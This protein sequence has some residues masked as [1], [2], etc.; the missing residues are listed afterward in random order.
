M[1]YLDFITDSRDREWLRLYVGQCAEVLRRVVNGHAQ[2]ILKASIDSLHYFMIWLG[3]GCRSA[4][5]IRLWKVED[6]EDDDWKK[7]RMNLL[8]ALF[9]QAFSTHHGVLDRILP[10]P[11]RDQFTFY[12]RPSYGLNLMTPLAQ[13]GTLIDWK[14]SNYIIPA[15]KTPD[16]Q[17]G[18]WVNCFRLRR[19]TAKRALEQK[20]LTAPRLRFRSDFDDCLRTAI[21]D[22]NL[23]KELKESMQCEQVNVNCSSI[24]APVP[25][26]GS[27]SAKVGFILDYAAVS[28]E[29]DS[30]LERP[31]DEDPAVQLPWSL[32]TCN[33]TESNILLWTY[34]FGKFLP[35]AEAIA[36]QNANQDELRLRHQQ[37]I[38]CSQVRII[39]LCGP[40]AEKAI[41]VP[42]LPRFTLKL[43]GF[44]YP[45]YLMDNPKRILIRCPPIP[46]EIWSKIGAESTQI[47]EG[48]RFAISLLGLQKE[49]LRPYSLETTSIIGVILR[50]ARCERLG[51][52]KMT[53]KTV[54]TPLLLWLQRKGLTTQAL[55]RVEKLAGSLSR[56]LLMILHALPRKTHPSLKRPM[57]PETRAI[58]NAERVRCYEPFDKD[59]FRQVTKIVQDALAEKEESYQKALQSLSPEKPSTL[60]PLSSSDP[61]TDQDSELEDSHILELEPF[62]KRA[63]DLGLL[64][65]RLS[66]T[67]PDRPKFKGHVWR[68]EVGIFRDKEYVYQMDPD[69]TRSRSINVN[70]CKIGFEKGENVGDGTIRVKIEVNPP[71][72]RHGK[73]YATDALDSDP[74]SRLAFR[75]R[76]KNSRGEQQE[77]YAFAQGRK[78]TYTAN[79][80]VD[81][82]VDDRPNEMIAK[83]SRRYLYFTSESK[84]PEELKRFVGGAY[85]ADI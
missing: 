37:L 40:R 77:K 66:E 56:G 9:C 11:G 43:R 49:G 80:L 73:C 25:F 6:H 67:N 63:V 23:F 83:T 51:R 55:E 41:G 27:T 74:A 45:I 22:D 58:K 38:D 82:L 70:Y 28:P 47:A 20:L 32:E 16:E 60:E 14:R 36:I 61:Y 35:L 18:L 52:E 68:Q 53:L 65:L 17:I 5:F 84:I 48:I 71:G 59:A 39:F 69:Q 78:S 29:E 79:T 10:T 3:N 31:N 57:D 13:V 30:F 62:C 24:T 12:E 76:Y 1:G 75:V 64:D 8:E 4:N 42:S 26:F 33:F 81:I 44:R 50:H 54:E 15:L 21:G 85:T 46:C 34:N 19:A 72:Q 2:S 7:I